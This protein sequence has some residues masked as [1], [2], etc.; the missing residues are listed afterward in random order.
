MPSLPHQVTPIE[1][2]M[3]SLDQRNAGRSFVVAGKNFDFGPKGPR[4]GFA[5]KIISPFP[6]GAPSKVQGITIQGRTLVFTS[7]AILTWRTSAPFMWELLYGFDTTIPDGYE[8]PWSAMYIDNQLWLSQPGRGMFSSEVTPGSDQLWLHPRTAFDIPGLESRIR[9]MD[10]VHSRAVMV[11]DDYIQWSGVGDMTDLT[12]A[13]G[14]AGI[15]A[16]SAFVQGTFLGLNSFQD[17]FVVWTTGGAVIGEYIGGDEVWAFYPLKTQLK[18]VGRRATVRLENGNIA[19]LSR[20]GLFLSNNSADVT[21]FSPEFN[22]YFLEYMYPEDGDLTPNQFWRVDYNPAR[23]TLFLSE[24]ADGNTYYRTFVF[25]PTRE[26][27][28]IF[29]DRHFGFL[30]LTPDTF[31]HVDPQGFAHYFSPIFTRETEPSNARGLNRIMPAGQKQGYVMSSSVVCRC[32]EWDSTSPMEPYNPPEAAWYSGATIVP[33]TYDPSP[34]DSWIEIGYVRPEQLAGWVNQTVEIQEMKL[35]SIPIA[36]NFPADYRTNH[37]KQW[38]YY[39]PE[40]W[41]S[42]ADI[43]I[44][45]ILDDWM[46]ASG[47]EDYL[48]SPD[49]T[50]DYMLMDDPSISFT[51]DSAEDWNNGGPAEDWN[52]PGLNLIPL[53]YDMQWLASQDGITFDTCIPKMARFNTTAQDWA[54][55]SGGLYH[56]IRIAATSQM[57]YYDVTL[58]SVTLQYSGNIG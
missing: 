42:P 44:F 39:T 47:D 50:E 1:T 2:F 31:G 34:L 6:F 13:L 24:S 5:S 20:Q 38:F 32:A 8:G 3:P 33:A 25:N 52:G 51:W 45:D 36:P 48:L 46:T 41:D 15:Q 53:T 29:S 26:K 7:D 27:W 19:F 16:L 12:P 21:P 28:G 54:G 30:A 49:T 17:G 56:R 11:N 14:G 37:H 18:P 58:M 40:D 9:G 10:I 22:E 23:E 55:L 43:D 4:S 57:Q 35:S